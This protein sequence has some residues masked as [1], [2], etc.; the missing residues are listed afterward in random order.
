[1]GGHLPDAFSSIGR[2]SERE[3]AGPAR[4]CVTQA[5]NRAK[6]DPESGHD[7]ECAE[8][9]MAEVLVSLYADR[10]VGLLGA[11][12]PG[13][14]L[15]RNVLIHGYMGRRCGAAAGE[16]LPPARTSRQC[17]DAASISSDLEL[18]GSSER[19]LD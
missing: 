19:S 15:P 14:K 9:R 6:Y 3:T 8:H 7:A 11:K 17:P 1:M 10:T 16:Q 4:C 2:L 12:G 5:A 13:E 18:N